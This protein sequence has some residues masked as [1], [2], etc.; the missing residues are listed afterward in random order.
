MV[1]RGKKF[2]WDYREYKRNTKKAIAQSLN[3]TDII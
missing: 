1:P 3:T 2:P